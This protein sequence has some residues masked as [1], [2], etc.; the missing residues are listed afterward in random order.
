M[1][2]GFYILIYI[3]TKLYPDMASTLI[4]LFVHKENNIIGE[5]KR[6]YLFL[7]K[8]FHWKNVVITHITLLYKGSLFGMFHN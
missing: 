7:D 2:G 1:I 4:W 5:E 3:H 6:I 8:I